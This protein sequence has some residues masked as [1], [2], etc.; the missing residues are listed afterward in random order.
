MAQQG[1]QRTLGLTFLILGVGMTISLA[2]T[3][4]PAFL[5][6]GLP[7]LVLGVVFL[8]RSKAES[9]AREGE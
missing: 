2:T 1:N 6:I 5:G 8:N 4:G 9:A 7:F 3:L